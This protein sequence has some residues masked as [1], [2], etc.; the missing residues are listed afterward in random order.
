MPPEQRAQVEAMMKGRM[1]G[2]AAPARPKV[3][4]RKGGSGTVGK[5]TCD[6]YE[7]YEG[8]RKTSEICTVDPKVLGFTVA[9][10]AVSQQLVEFFRKLI[11]Q[12]ANQMFTLGSMEQQGFSGVPVRRTFTIAGRE[13]TSEIT[14]VSRQTFADATYAPPAGYQK[15]AFGPGGRR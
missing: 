14:D 2:A 3:Q 4:Y 11:P 1:G 12:M 15:T 10:F 6:K 8:D 7:G 13:V 9:D 5:W